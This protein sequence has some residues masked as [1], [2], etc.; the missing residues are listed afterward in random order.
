MPFLY[1]A[2]PAFMYICGMVSF[3]RSF[4]VTLGIFA[5]FGVLVVFVSSVVPLEGTLDVVDDVDKL[6]VGDGAETVVVW[7]PSVDNSMLGVTR[8][9]I[10]G[11][12]EVVGQ[13]TERENIL[14]FVT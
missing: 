6:T 11:V 12:S 9:L 3:W 8:V 4:R 13:R 5:F 14:Y 1:E 2:I 7:R 10:S